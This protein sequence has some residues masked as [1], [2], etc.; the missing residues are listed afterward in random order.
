MSEPQST[1]E[2][3]SSDQSQAR[4]NKRG[5]NLAVENLEKKK[6]VSNR[7][8]KS[9]NNKNTINQSASA[10]EQTVSPL[11]HSDTEANSDLSVNSDLIEVDLSPDQSKE[12]K[13]PKLKKRYILFIG[14][15]PTTATQEDVISHFEK[16]G[17]SISEFRLLTHKDT[18]KS[19]CCGF[20]EL[21]NNKVMQNALK[22]HRSRLHGKHVNIEVTC[23]G[24][25]KTETRRH[26]IMK[27]NR[28]LRKKKAMANPV[29]H[30]N[31]VT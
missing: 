2:L 31:R 17:V 12:G 18:G 30:K 10:S 26:K 21:S 28:T 23:G 19:K 1:H 6:S 29:I 3:K 22:F 25:G 4:S 8:F 24:G 5:R 11:G 27:K 15:L 20:L 13:P 14:N 16:R 9:A 7:G